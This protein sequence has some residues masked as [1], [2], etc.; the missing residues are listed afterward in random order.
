MKLFG[1]LSLAT[2]MALCFH[3]NDS[4]A[5]TFSVVRSFGI[6]TNVTGFTP[7]APLVQGPDG[8]LYGTTVSAE[9][10]A[11][12]TVFKI[13][14]DGTGLTAL[15]V[16]TN[17]VDGYSPSGALLLNGT[18]LY[19]TTRTGGSAAFGNV[20]KINT[21]GSGF[22]VIKAFATGG[23]EGLG[24]VGGLVLSGSTLYGATANGGSTGS[25]TVFS[26][27]TDGTGFTVL[28]NFGSIAND[29]SSPQG[30]LVLSGST[31][32]GTTQGGGT[33][34]D[35]TIFKINTDGSS[36]SILKNFTGTASDGRTPLAG[37]LLSGSTLYGTTYFGGANNVGVVF[38]V[39][40]SGSG[41]QV[42][43]SFAGGTDAAKPQSALVVGG[44]TLYGTTTYGGLAGNSGTVFALSTDGNTYKLLKSFWLRSHRWRRAVRRPGFERDHPIWNHCPGRRGG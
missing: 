14:P 23:L 10:H 1:T 44:T 19:G 42:I 31:L 12:G 35:G 41:F 18:T 43:K 30:G 39:A 6:A 36:Y 28:K 26:V 20:F 13:Q 21:D 34:F 40:T 33:L 27:N 3:P 17:A 15:K 37:L 38:S 8:T 24:P 29:G 7:Q 2:L 25:G 4:R 5:Q 11:F 16:F 22:T 32:Y 9:G